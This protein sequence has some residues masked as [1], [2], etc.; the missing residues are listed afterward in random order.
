[1]RTIR[2]IVIGMILFVMG[3]LA[4]MFIPSP[5]PQAAKPWEIELM[6]DGNIQVFGIHLGT[7]DYKTAQKKLGAFGETALFSD[8]DDKLSVEAFFDSTNLSGLSAKMV[9]TLAVSQSELQEMMT[10]TRNAKLQP[11]GAHQHEI[12]E[13]DREKLLDLPVASITY[14][15][16]LRLDKAML[17]ERF[18]EPDSIE[19]IAVTEANSQIENWLYRDIH[20]IVQFNGE[21]KPIL[22]YHSI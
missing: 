2:N 4:I 22:I 15:P 21:A 14:I 1:M 11:S 5:Q 6:S 8:P 18:G 3:L 9:M 16:S 7:T 19:T 17:K 13:S 12:S 20:L 10:Q